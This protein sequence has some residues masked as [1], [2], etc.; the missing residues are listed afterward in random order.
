MS[1]PVQLFIICPFTLFSIL[2][3][4]SSLKYKS[5]SQFSFCFSF[6]FPFQIT[7]DLGKDDFHP[8]EMSD[9]FLLVAHLRDFLLRREL[10]GILRMIGLDLWR[11]NQLLFWLTLSKTLNSHFS[12]ARRVCWRSTPSLHLHQMLWCVLYQVLPEVF[13]FITSCCQLIYDLSGAFLGIL[14]WRQNDKTA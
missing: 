4:F 7:A 9:V 13:Q 3:L 11:P 2:S 14:E 8:L 5:H 12:T 10:F 1:L 6:P